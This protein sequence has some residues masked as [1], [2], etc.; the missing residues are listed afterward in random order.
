MRHRRRQ[1]RGDRGKRISPWRAALLAACLV[2]AGSGLRAAAEETAP[3]GSAPASNAWM[4]GG[5]PATAPT[6]APGSLP[7]VA[8]A[9]AMPATVIHGGAIPA[10]WQPQPIPYQ[11]LGADGKHGGDLGGQ[12]QRRDA[13]PATADHV[14][15]RDRGDGETGGGSP[16][17]DGR[18]HATSAGDANGTL[19]VLEVPANMRRK[20][21][22]EKG[23][24]VA[25]LEREERR[26]A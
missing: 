25:F 22:N 6:P 21:T 20:I 2:V 4:T 18:A 10:G 23:L 16:G 24:F 3:S 12:R 19:H 8:Q 1:E 9:W 26:V 11:G 13:E 5:G 15:R 14:E 17:S 7:P